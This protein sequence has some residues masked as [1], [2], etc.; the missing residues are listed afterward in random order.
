ML[1]TRIF[2]GT[3]RECWCISEVGFLNFYKSTVGTACIS[4]LLVDT[5]TFMGRGVWHLLIDTERTLFMGIG[6]L[7]VFRICE[8]CSVN[9]ISQL[10]FD[11][12]RQTN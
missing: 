12:L 6:I 2:A 7:V 11:D 5:P 4:F 1:L 10:L 8:L 9:L 3:F